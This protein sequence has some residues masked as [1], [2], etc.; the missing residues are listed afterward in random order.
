[1]QRSKFIWLFGILFAIIVSNQFVFSQKADDTPQIILEKMAAVYA[2][3]SSYQDSGFVIDNFRDGSSI[4]GPSLTFK[5][6]F[7]RPQKYRFEWIDQPFLD[8]V[9]YRNI[10]WNDGQDTYSSYG[11]DSNKLIQK[12][13]LDLGISSATGVSR[14]AAQTIS[15][16]LMNEISGFRLTQLTKLSLLKQ[17]KFEGVNCFVIRGERSHSSVDLWIGTNDFL[18]RKIRS[19]NYNLSYNLTYTEEIRRNIK[20]NEEIPSEIF[21][22]LQS[23]VRER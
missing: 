21:T 16:L 8:E 1:M 3:S 9:K 23:S 20:L 11:W 18:L 13:S 19:R 5:T 4:A 12:S 15:V 2:N 6:Y 7:S 17:K 10:V 14:G 22:S